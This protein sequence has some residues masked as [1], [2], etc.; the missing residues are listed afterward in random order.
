MPSK[1]ESMG[2]TYASPSIKADGGDASQLRMWLSRSVRVRLQSVQVACNAVRFAATRDSSSIGVI[3][4]LLVSDSCPIFVLLVSFGPVLRRKTG[5]GSRVDIPSSRAVFLNVFSNVFA[6]VLPLAWD[7]PLLSL[8][9]KDLH[10]L[11][12]AEDSPHG[13]WGR[14]T[15]RARG[16]PAPLWFWP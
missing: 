3:R 1:Q 2:R 14:R 11:A 6:N 8:G 13:A 12:R 10:L 5:C 4:V 7:P 16:I 15:S 9:Q